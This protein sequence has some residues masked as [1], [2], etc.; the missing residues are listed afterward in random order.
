MNEMNSATVNEPVK[1]VIRNSPPVL[2]EA[3]TGAA[4]YLP[5]ETYENTKDIIEALQFLKSSGNMGIPQPTAAPNNTPVPLSPSSSSH[6]QVRPG[7]HP[8]KSKVRSPTALSNLDYITPHY[9]KVGNIQRSTTRTPPPPLLPALAK[10]DLV[11]NTGMNYGTMGLIEGGYGHSKDFS[12]R[13][14]VNNSN[15]DFTRG[16]DERINFKLLRLERA[17]SMGTLE[18]DSSAW[19]SS[20]YGEGAHTLLGTSGLDGNRSTRGTNFSSSRSSNKFLLSRGINYNDLNNHRLAALGPQ[21]SNTTIPS[22]MDLGSRDEPY[23]STYSRG[24]ASVSREICESARWSSTASKTLS[25]GIPD[26][27]NVPSNGDSSLLRGKPDPNHLQ[28][29]SNYANIRLPYLKEESI[30]LPPPVSNACSFL[31]QEDIQDDLGS[32]AAVLSAMRSS[33]FVRDSNANAGSNTGLPYTFSRPSSST[34]LTHS[35]RRYL[36]NRPRLIVHGKEGSESRPGLDRSESG[37][38]SVPAYRDFSA[39]TI[40]NLSAGNEAARMDHSPVTWNKGGKRIIFPERTEK[41]GS[42]PH[43]LKKP[44]KVRRRRNVANPTPLYASQSG[45][46]SAMPLDSASPSAVSSWEAI[47]NPTP[48]DISAKLPVTTPVKMET[49][50]KDDGDD[51]KETKTVI[52]GNKKLPHKFNNNRQP[53]VTKEGNVGTRSRKG[54]WI[55]RLR[56][57]KCTED[58]PSCFNC[59][60][61]NLTCLY[62]DKKPDFI[63]N[64]AKKSKKLDEI[65]EKTKIAKRNAMRKERRNVL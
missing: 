64:P 19:G 59:R 39:D 45:E 2:D 36:F 49:V 62:S 25:R 55:C 33:P 43:L 37:S 11:E 16:E 42:Q 18:L 40:T 14:L 12:N 3:C 53:R 10:I 32:A 51:S 7:Q 58:K 23:N 52:T 5:A 35:S 6:N 1:N 60:R 27:I 47:S 38:T 15:Y 46:T 30:E 8:L 24:V 48:A 28:T 41:R 26:G 9:E 13:T 31:G 57:K 22:I 65:R 63:A 34:R 50:D 17:P 20:R 29:P 54:C 4:E 61:L 44:T 56:K 21:Y